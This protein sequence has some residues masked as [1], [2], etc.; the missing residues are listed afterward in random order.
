MNS[1]VFGKTQENLWNRLHVELITDACIL[2]KRVAKPS[3]CR[4][5]TINDCLTVVQRKVATLTR[6]GSSVFPDRFHRNYLMEINAAYI[7]LRPYLAFCT[8]FGRVK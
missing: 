3:F 7:R 6:G 2:H 1:C 5:N 4:G 8:L